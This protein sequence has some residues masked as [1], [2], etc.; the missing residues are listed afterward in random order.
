MNKA[1]FA[2]QSC[3]ATWYGR[4]DEAPKKCPRCQSKNVG[5][6]KVACPACGMK[7]SPVAGKPGG[8]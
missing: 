2:C 6:L 5:K 7:F 4:K 1:P 8:P 3:G